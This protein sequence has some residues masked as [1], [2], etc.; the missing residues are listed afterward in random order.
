MSCA[1]SSG[2][3]HGARLTHVRRIGIGGRDLAADGPCFV[4]GEAGV[5]HNGDLALAHRLVDAAS[6]AGA[7]AVKFQTFSAAALVTTSSPKAGYQLQTTDR[8][9]S[10]FAMLSRLELGRE[11][12]AELKRHAERKGIVFLSTP[13]DEG[14]AD[15]LGDLGVEAFKIA[16][17][18]ITNV[19][20]LAHVAR[21]GKPML[22][23]TGM[24]TMGEIEEA[25]GVV[26]A[27]GDPPVVL[28]HCV[29][30]YP[31]DPAEANLRAIATLRG[32]FGLPVGYSDHTP[33]IEVSLAAVA[34]GAR[35]I[36]KHVTLDRSLP[37]PDQAASIEPPELDALVK[38]I[39]TIER[40]LGDG[41]KRPTAR[42][43][44]TA[45]ALRRSLVTRHAIK[46]GTVLTD[47]M[48]DARRPGTGI[49]PAMRPYVVGRRVRVD[50]PA[51][52]PIAIDMLE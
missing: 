25:L 3:S 34:L 21:L 45:R 44:D 7:D 2:M 33:G 8:A 47:E 52:A 30:D 12:F 9:E 32:A 13:F 15:L 49:P 40:A 18:E 36:E 5:N 26:T 23:S 39:R 16:S 31:A 41:R 6:A 14:S 22:I 27:A 17:S 1:I 11:A 19:A 20:L 38:G 24:A 50:L 46:A 35:V 28:L 37:G 10:Q 43:R 51:E 42:E 29:S 4:I 48:L